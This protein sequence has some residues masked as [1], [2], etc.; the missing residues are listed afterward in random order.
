MINTLRVVNVLNK[1]ST[2]GAE[3]LVRILCEGGSPSGAEIFHEC[4]FLANSKVSRWLLRKRF[5]RIIPILFFGFKIMK[6]I[7]FNSSRKS[8][9]RIYFIFHLAECH[10]AAYIYRFIP[11]IFKSVHFY[12]YLHQ[13]RELFPKK[14]IPLT[15]KLLAKFP[16]ICYSKSATDSWFLKNSSVSGNRFILHNAISREFYSPRFSRSKE[17]GDVI[18][19]LFIG[20]FAK[21]KKPDLALEFAVAM[22][23]FEEV[24]LKF[25]GFDEKEFFETYRLPKF[26]YPNLKVRFLGMNKEVVQYLFQ[27]NL[28]LY[29]ADAEQSGE[30]IGIAALEALSSG[31]PVMVANNSKTDFV[32]EPGILQLVDFRGSE[33]DFDETKIMSLVDRLKNPSSLLGE[34]DI[35]NWREKTSIKRYNLNLINILNSEI[36]NMR[37]QL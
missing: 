4:I 19:L 10:I 28:M 1:N 20:R 37:G 36:K 9:S 21:W 22:S 34:R 26:D 6:Y 31:L 11:K 32:G 33:N 25:I 29:F 16:A 35:T 5:F 18:Q 27:S 3:S 7:I 12:I 2:G 23:K 15:E 17:E 24:H 13:S 30:S 14:V 8:E